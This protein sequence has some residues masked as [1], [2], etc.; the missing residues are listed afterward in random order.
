[1]ANGEGVT[2]GVKELLQRID[3][4]IDRIE[5]SLDLK[6]DSVTVQALQDRVEQVRQ[7][8]YA[9]QGQ[10][11]SLRRDVDHVRTSTHDLRNDMVK[12]SGATQALKA[13]ETY[14]RYIIAGPVLGF[15]GLIV[16]IAALVR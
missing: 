15:L 7:E 8:Q 12:I 1:M 5:A 9:A 10:R 14:K 11:D 6:A 13:V 3:L 4:K 16:A 2:Y